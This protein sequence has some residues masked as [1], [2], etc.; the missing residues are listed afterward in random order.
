MEVA[1]AN[2]QDYLSVLPRRYIVAEWKHKATLGFSAIYLCCAPVSVFPLS[3]VVLLTLHSYWLP[4]WRCARV[5]DE[6]TSGRVAAHARL[7]KRQKL[8]PFDF[9]N[10]VARPA[11]LMETVPETITALKGTSC[12]N[13]VGQRT[14]IASKG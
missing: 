1:S 3:V 2:F 8:R 9:C 10:D 11:R 6:H 5:S 7:D 13:V 12:Q 4:I 14:G